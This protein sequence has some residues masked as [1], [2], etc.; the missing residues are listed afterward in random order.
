MTLSKFES[1]LTPAL[2][3]NTIPFLW[4]FRLAQYT[5]EPITDD[6]ALTQA[7]EPENCHQ[8]EIRYF[9]PYLSSPLICVPEFEKN[10]FDVSL[11]RYKVHKDAYI[12]TEEL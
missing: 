1:S 8:W 3:E 10:M 9:W 12:L 6:V 7:S 4:E 2:R 11:Y 5:G